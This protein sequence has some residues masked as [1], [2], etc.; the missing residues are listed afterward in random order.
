MLLN[1]GK[2][3]AFVVWGVLVHNTFEYDIKTHINEKKRV[4]A[5][6]CH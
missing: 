3:H 2:L 4:K 1:T 5:E 6:I